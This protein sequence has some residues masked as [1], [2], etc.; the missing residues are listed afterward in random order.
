MTS[1]TT[2]SAEIK[3]EY[4]M[5]EAKKHLLAPFR[6]LAYFTATAGIFAL[7]F[8]VQYLA[9][10]A[11]PIYV[12]RLTAIVVAFVLLILSYFKTGKKRP[13]FL[14]HFLLITIILS[15]GTIIFL[16][17]ATFT[18]NSH[19]LS[20]I[21]FT[22]A[23]FLSWDVTNQIIVAI[24]Y[25]VV[26]AASI[27]LT[28]KSILL[29]P[30]V[31]ESVLLV[32]FISVMA[33][34]ASAV[35]YRLRKE[36]IQK[37]MEV[38]VSEKK[39]RNIFENS[40]EGIFQTTMDG[41]FLTANLSLAKMLAVN[42]EEDVLNLNLFKDVFKRPGDVELLNKLFEKQSKIKNFRALLKRSDNLD[43]FAKMNIRVGYNEENQPAYYEGSIID[44]TQQVMAEA[45]RQKALDALRDEKTKIEIT[46]Q[47]ARQESQYKTKFLASMSHEIRT[48][49]N[50][51]MGFLTLVE[52]DLFDDKEEMK[53]FAK[54]VRTA[55]DTLLQIINNILDISKIEAGKME[56]NIIEF[57]LRQEV[58]KALAIIK[59][60]MKSKGLQLHSIIDDLI[61]DGLIGDATRYRQIILNLLSNAHKY[62]DKGEVTISL[63]CVER[64]EESVTILTSVKDTGPGIPKEKISK[65]FEAYS[66]LDASQSIKGTGLGLLICKEFVQL[67]G[68]EINVESKEGTGTNFYFTVMFKISESGKKE[69]PADKALP[70]EKPLPQEIFKKEPKPLIENLPP[71]YKEIIEETREEIEK[72]LEPAADE[73]PKSDKKT[74]L[75]VEDNPIS[76]SL[77]LKILREVGY[78]VEAVSNGTDA[79]TAIKTGK[80]H[81]VLMDIE[82]DD[83]DGITATK[84]VRSL[85]GRVANIPIIAVT[86]HSSMKDREMCINGGM[87]DYIAKPINIH[88]LKITIDQWLNSER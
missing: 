5:E 31:F 1:N 58:D 73:E 16:I 82:M 52:N 40:A 14:V 75:L 65:L 22:A 60:A 45:E 51:I 2:K 41:K 28:D 86:A 36:S 39:F 49:M 56:L 64:S 26:F 12:S 80:F 54:D 42:S 67:M 27:L 24:Y 37:S 79:I 19:I 17:P 88:F 18:V 69:I 35:N 3:Q 33:V 11:V 7:F 47:R 50:S 78:N 55:S 59:Q 20:L 34:V 43:L 70:A 84:T 76:Q 32:L 53:T 72:A 83:M 38:S 4:L 62:T 63:K 13:V 71:K 25:N 6:A 57:N 10:H 15:F 68:G 44:I 8:E 77:E 61:P 66:Q 21:I 30:N 46:A 87:D 74:L 9:D 23:L 48:P 29:L 85:P 81:L